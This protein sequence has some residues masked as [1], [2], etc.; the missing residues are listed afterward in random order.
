ME[1]SICPG[2]I[3]GTKRPE[4][5]PNSACIYYMILGKYIMSAEFPQQRRWW[6]NLAHRYEGVL[7]KFIYIWGFNK[8]MPNSYEALRIFFVFV[9]NNHEII[10]IRKI[11]IKFS[12]SG[13]YFTFNQKKTLIVSICGSQKNFSKISC[14]HSMRLK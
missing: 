13:A 7:N 9:F 5:N 6:Y 11:V 3:S 4:L 2:K 8:T 10:I 1:D 12:V 14:E